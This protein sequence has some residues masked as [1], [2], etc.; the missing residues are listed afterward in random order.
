MYIGLCVALALAHTALALAPPHAGVTTTPFG[1]IRARR[2]SSS[3]PTRGD[4]SLLHLSAPT[5][6]TEITYACFCY[7]KKK[8]ESAFWHQPG[9]YTPLNLSA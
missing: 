6:Q 5:K 2:C 3:S 9:P 8:G 4:L 1:S 7:T